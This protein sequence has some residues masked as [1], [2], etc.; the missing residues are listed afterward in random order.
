ME[1]PSKGLHEEIFMAI[2]TN[3]NTVDGG[4]NA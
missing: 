2:L 4:D 3:A 1:E